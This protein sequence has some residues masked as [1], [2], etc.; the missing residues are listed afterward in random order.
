MRQL[1]AT[2]KPAPLTPKG[3]APRVKSLTHLDSLLHPAAV[4]KF[5]ELKVKLLLAITLPLARLNACNHNTNI[6]LE[7]MATSHEK[8]SHRMGTA[9]AP[10]A[11]T[12]Q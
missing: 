11:T 6:A 1:K 10:D 7:E 9:K 12:G 3:A 5:S 2:S 4:M 8:T